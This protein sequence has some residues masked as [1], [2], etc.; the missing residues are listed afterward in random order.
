MFRFVHRSTRAQGR[1]SEQAVCLC[2]C[3]LVFLFSFS[4]LVPSTAFGAAAVQRVRQQKQQMA[5]AVA[6]QQYQQAQQQMMAQQQAQAVAAYQQAQQQAAYQK[7]AMEYAAYK[8]Q[9]Q[10]A[11]AKR[12]AEIEAANQMKQA[13]AQRQSQQVAEVQQ[14]VA[15]K[16]VSQVIAYKQAQEARAIA[17]AQSQAE[18]NQQV[19]E[20]VNYLTKRKAAFAQQVVSVQQAREV[21][22]I[23]A[24]DVYQK[25][26]AEKRK[27]A[28]QSRVESEDSQH[29]IGKKIAQEVLT[30][31]TAAE[32]ASKGK[33]AEEEP[34][35]VVGIAEL[36]SALDRSS[37]AWDKIVDEEIKLLTVAEYVDRF[38]KIGVKIKKAPGGYVK[39]IDALSTQ[40]P[41]FLD[42]PFMNVLSYAAIVEYD[43]ENGKNKDE[44]ARQTLGEAG[45]QA[46]RRR[47]EGH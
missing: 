16:Q 47:L 38:G 33:S 43:F 28:M 13:I 18:V 23:A 31:K 4:F 29:R 20:Y 1:K 6:Q 37:R 46:N 27:T 8:Q 39:F 24:Y 34:Q 14:A 3:V 42:A 19:Q 45:F 30:P 10:A 41:E 12:N 17:L 25:A 11:I 36:W 40:N 35:T 2:F 7:A 21:Q 15:N 5:Q 32:D 44:L 9:M 22:S 26:T